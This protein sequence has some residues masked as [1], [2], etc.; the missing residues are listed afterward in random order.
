MAADLGEGARYC[1]GEVVR[2]MRPMVN[3]VPSAASGQAFE[4]D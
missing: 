4:A 1:I 2:P 3:D